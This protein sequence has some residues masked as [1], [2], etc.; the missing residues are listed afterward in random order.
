MTTLEAGGYEV[1]VVGAAAA[2]AGDVTG[3][4]GTGGENR[5]GEAEIGGLS[6]LPVIS[7]L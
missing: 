4:D 1:L 6:I 3:L 5:G 7:G 2:G